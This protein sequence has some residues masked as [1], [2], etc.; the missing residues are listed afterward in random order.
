MF[1]FRSRRRAVGTL[2]LGTAAGI[3]VSA[4]EK[5]LQTAYRAVVEARAR[6]DADV[7]PPDRL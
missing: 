3:S 4:V 7:T 6:L 5:H 1:P 2:L